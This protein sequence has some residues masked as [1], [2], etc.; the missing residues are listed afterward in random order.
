MLSTF[1]P[2][3]Q[4]NGVE[5]FKGEFTK[6]EIKGPA[7]PGRVPNLWSTHR[8]NSLSTSNGSL[9]GTMSIYT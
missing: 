9:P 8:R 3:R 1:D 2:H 7:R 6:V 5:T 4:A